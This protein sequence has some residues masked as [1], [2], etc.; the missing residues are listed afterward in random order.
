M[1]KA[2]TG[3]RSLT[4]LGITATFAELCSSF[5]LLQSTVISPSAS[6]LNVSDDPADLTKCPVSLSP[7]INK[8]TSGSGLA[9]P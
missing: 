2:S 8:R 1:L 3:L 4:F 7:S 6:L 9:C 5:T